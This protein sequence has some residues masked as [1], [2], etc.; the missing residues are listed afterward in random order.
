MFLPPVHA[1]TDTAVLL[2]FI[3]E[4]PLGLLITGIKSSQNFLQCT[5]VPFVLDTPEESTELAPKGRL[6]AHIAKKNPQ[7]TAM[8][9]GLERKPSVLDIEDSVLV[10]FNGKHDHYVT[11]K[12][13]VET[14]PD[15]GKV[16]PTW[17]YSAVQRSVMGY[18]G[19]KNPQP[20]TVSDAPE[21][22]IEFMQRNIV[23]IEIRIEE[24]QGKFKMSQE[25]KPG[26]REGVVAGFA[27]MGGETGEAISRLVRQRGAL[28]DLKTR[29]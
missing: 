21:K 17:N 10:V 9:E 11:P 26:D 2:Q 22:Y 4:N 29:K 13:Y 1:E 7:V 27:Q 19:G 12:Y 18:T 15:T 6:R 16:V 14:K 3:R 8:I 25:M 28:H 23:G 20:W 24:I 5:H